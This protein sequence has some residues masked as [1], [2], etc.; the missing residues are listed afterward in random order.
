[1]TT[2]LFHAKLFMPEL[3]TAPVH[4]GR[5]RYSAHALR[6]SV[7]DKYGGIELPTEFHSVGAE[8]IEAEVLVGPMTVTKQVW[9]Q[10]LDSERDLVLV[11]GEYGLVRTVWINLK[12]DKHRSLDA[13]RYWSGRHWRAA[14]QHVNVAFS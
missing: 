7:S 9:R 11:I 8:L 6:E 10:T 14:L 2:A 5:L 13:S 12:R 4:E 1:M 3:A